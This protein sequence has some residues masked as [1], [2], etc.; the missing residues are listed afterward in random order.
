MLGSREETEA[1]SVDPEA[2]TLK[3][4][5]PRKR[6]AD[7]AIY[8]QDLDEETAEMTKKKQRD[9]EAAWSSG[10]V[11]ASPQRSASSLE[12]KAE[13][14][15]TLIN[16][17]FPHYNSSNVLATPVHCAPLPALCWASKDVVWTNMLAKDK[18]YVRDVNMMEKHPHL[19]PKM[20]AILL[21]WLMEVSEVYKLHRETYHMAQDYFDRFMATQRNVFKSTLQLIGISCLFIA[22]KV[23]EMYPPKVHQFAYVTD[24]ACTEDE[25]L[26]MEVIIMKELKWS[27]SPQTPVSWLNVYMQVAYL[28]ESDEL[29]IPK[30]PQATFAHIAELLDVCLLDTR[31]LEF[32]NGV[33]AASA[34]FHFSSLE[35]VENV[36][37]LKRAELEECVRWM[38]PFAMALRELG[39]APM[40]T[41]AGIAADDMHNIQPHAPYLSWLEKASRYEDADLERHRSCQLP[42]GVLTPPLS[43]EKTE[44]PLGADAAASLQVRP[45]MRSPAAQVEHDWTVAP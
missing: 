37:A 28:K 32:S 38:V 24:E 10:G 20:R 44:S 14:R 21:D 41:F 8:L 13:Q 6:K 34:L 25:I 36:S 22:A 40:K 29:L 23:E 2:A 45:R 39:G 5:R 43:S 27:L 12:R 17:G 42:S 4:T 26:S 33:L 16:V 30:Y 3:T 11:Y 15:I 18:T 1:K 35:L 19:Q 31:C 7:V 9:S